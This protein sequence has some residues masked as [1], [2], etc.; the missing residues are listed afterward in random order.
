MK[1]IQ[2]PKEN[3]LLITMKVMN[4]DVIFDIHDNKHFDYIQC[5]LDIRL[6]AV[7]IC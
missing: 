3:S 6:M 1:V 2:T 4:L 7:S 5:Y